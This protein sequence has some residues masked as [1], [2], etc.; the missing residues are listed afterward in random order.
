MRASELV[1]MMWDRLDTLPGGGATYRLG[2][3]KTDRAGTGRTLYLRPE[4]LQAL[5]AW[6]LETPEAGRIFHAVADDL[7]LDPTTA[8]SA[9]ERQRW[10]LR[11]ARAQEQERAALSAREVSA[12][13]RRAAAR[14]GLDPHTQ[15]LSSHSA[16]VGAAQDMVRSGA[17]TAQ[18]QVAG[19]CDSERMPIRYA[20][21][22]MAR[23]AG[24][25]RFARLA[26][27]R[28]GTPKR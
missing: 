1:A 9:A 26:A 6:R 20:E 27:M 23:D 16:R 2:R 22:V 18:V 11:V 24:E 21:R 25:N 8:I 4:T 7:F 15:W 14:A 10:T 17:T 5:D 28:R 3:T 12:I 19:R 13:F